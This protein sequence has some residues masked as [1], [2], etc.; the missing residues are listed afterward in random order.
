MTIKKLILAIC[1]LVLVMG[2]VSGCNT[3]K[4]AGQ[5]VSDTGKTIS[6]AASAATP[7]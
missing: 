2:L 1:P 5:D 3:V 6:N 7:R 4:G